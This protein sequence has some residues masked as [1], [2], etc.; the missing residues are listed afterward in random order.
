[1]MGPINNACNKAVKIGEFIDVD[2]LYLPIYCKGG[3]KDV[4]QHGCLI[5]IGKIGVF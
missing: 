1:M 3:V 4:K 2:E 5:R